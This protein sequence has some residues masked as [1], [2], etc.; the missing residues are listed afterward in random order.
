MWIALFIDDRF[1]TPCQVSDYFFQ[2]LLYPKQKVGCLGYRKP[3]VQFNEFTIL[4]GKIGL[5]QK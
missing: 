3:Y 5:T 2:F 1:Y 4:V